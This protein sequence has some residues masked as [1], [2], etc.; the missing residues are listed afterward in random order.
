MSSL[1]AG[2]ALLAGS[3]GA[4]WYLAPRTGQSGLLL[5]RVPILASTAPMVITVG[6]TLGIVFTIS[7]L[8]SVW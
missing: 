6:V 2:S 7:G 5:D 8:I 4:L 3:V 1:L